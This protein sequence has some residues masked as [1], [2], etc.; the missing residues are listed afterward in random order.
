MLLDNTSFLK[1]VVTTTYSQQFLQIVVYIVLYLCADSTEGENDPELTGFI[2]Y[3]SGYTYEPT[4]ETVNDYF[5]HIYTEPRYMRWSRSGK[6][7]SVYFSIKL[8]LAY[9]KASSCYSHQQRH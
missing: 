3:E 5:E 1:K 6:F 9:S 7:L 8:V 4:S 2:V